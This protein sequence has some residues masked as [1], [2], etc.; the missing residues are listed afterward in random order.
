MK[1]L[2]T[3]VIVCILT[4]GL[5]VMPASAESAASNV[6]LY[7]TVNAEGDALVT[8]QVMLR[9]E[10]NYEQLYF[11]LPVNAKNITLNGSGV[12]STKSSSATLVNISRITEGYLGEATMRF[13]YT[14]PEAVSVNTESVLEMLKKGQDVKDRLLLTL[15][16]LNG[17]E[18][19]V[20]TMKFTVT[21]P[22]GKMT[23]APKFTSIYRQ[24]SIE[25][26]LTIL[27]ITGSQ[28]IGTAKTVMNDRE[29]ITMTMIVPEEMFPTVSTYV[30]NGNPELL[31]IG[32]FAGLALL[33]WLLTL[34]TLPIKRLE[35]NT[36]IEGVTAG[37]M[38]CRLTLA[39]GDLTMMVFTWAQLGYL[40]ISADDN[41]QVLLHKR[42][43]MG[44]ERGPFEN[45][46]FRQ[47]FGN[48]RVVDATGMTYAK[49]CIKTA[50][51]V[52][53]E[54][55]VFRGN[56]GN[57]KIFRGL[58]CVCQIFAGV[59]VA[60]NLSSR[61]WLATIMAV[62]LGVFGAIT[63]WLIQDVA[64]RT[65]LRGKVPVLIG[66]ICIVI[67]TILGLLSGQVWIPL[68]VSLGNWV[69]GYFA[70]YGGRR[71]DLGRHD[72]GQVLGLRKHLKRMPKE[73][74]NRLMIND[75]EYFF[76][77]APY[78]LALGVMGPFARAFGGRK[79]DQCPYLMTRVAGK[80]TAEEWGQLMQDTADIMDAKS[81]RLQVEKWV[82]LEINFKLPRK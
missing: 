79:F 82:P 42:M 31:P 73:S 11:P 7:I 66:L 6:D 4:A 15:P 45:K 63:G 52:P 25:S 55:N 9:L 37:E 46:V 1:R 30:R 18:L 33:Y 76:N 29:G 3:L 69:F 5:L 81:R 58:A 20:E 78:A 50:K 80:R 17:F 67:W 21:M 10:S 49:L 43:D 27:P 24:D 70:A 53:Q 39:G 65:H 38:G 77:Y 68:G 57:I 40:I 51:Q 34:R 64:Y 22:A 56:S 28:I 60:M 59:C 41:G 72:A 75:P 61:L 14:I 71:S 23:H 26:D 74:I 35:T 12:T 16:L 19:P 36:A 2:L 48:R 13:E 44:N 54:R 47:L 62:I 32:I 8:M